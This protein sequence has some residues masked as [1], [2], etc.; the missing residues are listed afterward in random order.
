M[1]GNRITEIAGIKIA[2]D[3]NHDER[4]RAALES[5]TYEEQETRALRGTLRPTDVVL[6]LGTASDCSPRTAPNASAANASSPLKPIPTS[7][8]SSARP[9]A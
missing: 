2:V 3:E 9:T 5:G 6:E 8:H 4:V 1:S 7:S